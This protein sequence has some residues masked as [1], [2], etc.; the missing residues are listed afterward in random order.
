MMGMFGGGIGANK[1]YVKDEVTKEKITGEITE[2]KHECEIIIK[3][4][5]E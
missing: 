2:L 3:P 5:S 1:I 4:Q